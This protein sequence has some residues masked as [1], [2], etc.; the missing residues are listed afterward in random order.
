[1]GR[2]ATGPL[3][4]ESAADFRK[5]F[6]NGGEGAL[7]YPIFLFSIL[8]KIIFEFIKALFQQS[9]GIC[10]TGATAKGDADHC[11]FNNFFS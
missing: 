9:N 1:M 7:A 4:G 3:S 2:P 8:P 6:Y 10:H 5:G 11:G